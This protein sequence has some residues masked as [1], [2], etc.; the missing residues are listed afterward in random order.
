MRSYFTQ[1]IN[2]YLKLVKNMKERHWFMEGFYASCRMGR[3]EVEISIQ[4]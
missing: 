3:G 4:F 2:E 1:K